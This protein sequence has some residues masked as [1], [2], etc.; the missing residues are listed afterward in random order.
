MYAG[1]ILDMENM[2]LVK[3]NTAPAYR[4]LLPFSERRKTVMK[5]SHSCIYSCR[6]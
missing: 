2:G 4:V 3:T 5:Q 1:T 6:L